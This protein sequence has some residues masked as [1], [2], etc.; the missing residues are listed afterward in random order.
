[1]ITLSPDAAHP[2]TLRCKDN[3]TQRHSTD[4]GGDPIVVYRAKPLSTPS[5]APVKQSLAAMLDAVGVLLVNNGLNQHQAVSVEKSGGAASLVLA[6]SSFFPGDSSFKALNVA[7]TL[8]KAQD[9]GKS[10]THRAVVVG[11][12]IPKVLIILLPAK[13]IDAIY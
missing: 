9:Q 11:A 6:Q 7:A 1:M 8:R 12:S 10:S 5:S 3:D 4:D 13:C 2:G